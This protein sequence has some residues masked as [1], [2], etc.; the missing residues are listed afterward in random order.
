M[1]YEPWVDPQRVF[2]LVLVLNP[3]SVGP[4]D[5]RYVIGISGLL[6]Q[7]HVGNNVVGPNLEVF[8]SEETQADLFFLSFGYRE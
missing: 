2:I 4:F 8:L 1:I 5:C 7:I 6:D 3:Q